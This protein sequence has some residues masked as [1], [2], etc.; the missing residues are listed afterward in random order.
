MNASETIYGGA[1]LSAS[2]KGDSV[3]GEVLYCE[4]QFTS[5][6]TVEDDDILKVTATLTAEDV[7]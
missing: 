2:T 3:S 7:V 1:L 4:S 6:R 5:S